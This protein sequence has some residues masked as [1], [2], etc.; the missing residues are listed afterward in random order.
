M[1][2][3]NEKNKC[4]QQDRTSKQVAEVQFDSGNILMFNCRFHPPSKRLHVPPQP[5]TSLSF[6]TNYWERYSV[7]SLTSPCRLAA[8]TMVC[9]CGRFE[10]QRDP[11]GLCL[12]LE[13]PPPAYSLSACTQGDARHFDC[14]HARLVLPEVI[15]LLCEPGDTPGQDNCDLHQQYRLGYVRACT[16]SCV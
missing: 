7:A 13:A 6:Y 2:D 4:A 10:P 11:L 3:A 9:T 14:V 15:Q 12:D 5:L 16:K 1:R 8:A